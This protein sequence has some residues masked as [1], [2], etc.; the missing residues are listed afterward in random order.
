MARQDDLFFR[1]GLRLF[2][3]ARST[4]AH[5]Q[6]LAEGRIR[7]VLMRRQDWGKFRSA[8]TPI[9]AKTGTYSNSIEGTWI[10]GVVVGRDSTGDDLH[11]VLGIAWDWPLIEP[12]IVYGG[13]SGTGSKGILPTSPDPARPRIKVTPQAQWPR[14]YVV[15]EAAPD[16]TGD[17]ELVLGEI[18]RHVR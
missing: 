5:F 4:I 16:I 7:D 6:G 13:F 12:L 11:L 8:S 2:A 10:H 15:P 9:S 14:L 1:E 17:L 3:E 18:L